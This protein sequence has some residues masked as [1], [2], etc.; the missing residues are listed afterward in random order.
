MLEASDGSPYGVDIVNG[1]GST[2][3]NDMSN[4]EE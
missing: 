2:K 4:R 3:S 1:Y